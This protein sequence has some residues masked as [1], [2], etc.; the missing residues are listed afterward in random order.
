MEEECVKTIHSERLRQ[1][2]GSAVSASG[3]VSAMMI[4]I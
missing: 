4:D 2:A 1:G 3:K